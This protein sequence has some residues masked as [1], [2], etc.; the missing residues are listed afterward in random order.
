MRTNIVCVCVHVWCCSSLKTINPGLE[1]FGTRN[2][3]QQMRENDKLE[4]D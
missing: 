4:N 2:S 1:Y 3:D